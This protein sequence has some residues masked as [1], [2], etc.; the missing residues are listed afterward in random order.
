MTLTP[1][2]A[3]SP[4]PAF[5]SG[6]RVRLRPLERSDVNVR[7]AAWLNDADV[8]RFLEV[9]TFPTSLVELEQFYASVA[10]RRDQVLL[11]IVDRETDAHVGNVKLGPIDWIHRRGT[12]GILV[13]ERSAWGRGIG[14][15]ATRLIIEYAFDRL[16]LRRIDLG[17][18]ADH[19]G[20]IR[21]YERVGFRVEGR[22]REDVYH[23]GAYRDR[24]WM[25]L[26]RSEY[27]RAEGGV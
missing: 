27:R 20:A 26:L 5:L 9:G 18:Y 4:A 10:T 1:P 6:A 15:E 8:T 11:A 19:A 16:D 23:G 22:F 14:T 17:V 12:L 24:L 13:G 2:D 21:V 25:G 3:L 7:Y